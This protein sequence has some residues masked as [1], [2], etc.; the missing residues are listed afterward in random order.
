MPPS[1]E[2][3]EVS[4]IRKDMIATFTTE[5]GQKVLRYLMRRCHLDGT[6]TTER[7]DPYESMFRDGERSVIVGIL[8][9]MQKPV[10][11]EPKELLGELEQGRYDY[12]EPGDT[13]GG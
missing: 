7:F 3:A 5:Q 1:N 12:T 8:A 13:E 10:L 6:S 2:Q 11:S 9:I 4:R